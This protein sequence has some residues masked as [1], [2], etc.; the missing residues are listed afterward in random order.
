MN[1]EIKVKESPSTDYD[2]KDFG[3]KPF[4]L[5]GGGDISSHLHWTEQNKL[6]KKLR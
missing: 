5:G 1:R 3:K 6:I 4:F 2:F